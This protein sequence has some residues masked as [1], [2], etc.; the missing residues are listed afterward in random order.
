MTDKELAEARE[1]YEVQYALAKGFRER[2]EELRAK[3]DRMEQMVIRYHLGKA[4]PADISFV[5]DLGQ[6][7]VRE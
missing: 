1:R 3:L 2:N 7:E 5:F 4:T 6:E